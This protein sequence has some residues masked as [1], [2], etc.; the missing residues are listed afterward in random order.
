M[1]G[2]SLK[3]SKM[4]LRYGYGGTPLNLSTLEVQMSYIVITIKLYLVSSRTVRAMQK[5]PVSE[6]QQQN[7]V[8]CIPNIINLVIVLVS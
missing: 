3:L 5:I 1:P 8:S 2:L 4:N 6:K 7:P